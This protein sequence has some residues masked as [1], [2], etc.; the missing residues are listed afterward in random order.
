MDGWRKRKKLQPSRWLIFISSFRFVFF[1]YF[2]VCVK[3]CHY[4]L[5]HT[6]DDQCCC[7]HCCCCCCCYCCCCSAFSM[8]VYLVCSF[9]FHFRIFHLSLF[10]VIQFSMMCTRHNLHH[11][12]YQVPF[13]LFLFSIDLARAFSHPVL[14]LHN[15]I[16]TLLSAAYSSLH[17]RILYLYM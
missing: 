14:L 5:F 12:H 13:F 9:A 16:A 3:R 10:T 6:V 2:L 7:C 15:V 17:R 1:L 11:K 4:F 8:G